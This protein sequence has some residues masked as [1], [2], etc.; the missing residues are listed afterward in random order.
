M[1]R[2]LGFVRV[3]EE[4]D[5]VEVTCDILAKWILLMWDCFC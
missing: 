2:L 1:E 4:V 5:S 3:Y